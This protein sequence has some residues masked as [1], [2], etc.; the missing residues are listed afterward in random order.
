LPVGST[1][2]GALLEVADDRLAVRGHITSAGTWLRPA[3]AFVLGEAVVPLGDARLPWASAKLGAVIET[4]ESRDGI[5]L[6]QPPLTGELPC[7]ALSLAR[8]T[9]ERSARGSGAAAETHAAQIAAVFTHELTPHLESDVALPDIALLGRMR[10]ALNAA[11]RQLS[12]PPG[13][14]ASSCWRTRAAGELTSLLV[15]AQAS[16]DRRVLRLADLVGSDGTAHV[17]VKPPVPM[18]SE[19]ASS[20]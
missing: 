16:V 7:D 12:L 1:A 18:L 8:A 9:Q 15:L 10:D 6:T 11:E 3:K 5:V 20:W 14:H 19:T 17:V 4:F 2:D 13:I